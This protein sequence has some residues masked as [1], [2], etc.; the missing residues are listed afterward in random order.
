MPFLGQEGHVLHARR[1]Y[2]ELLLRPFCN[3]EGC[4]EKSW[5]DFSLTEH[6]ATSPPN[7]SP[8]GE[9][10]SMWGY[11]YWPACTFR[12]V[13]FLTELTDLTELFH[14]R[15][16]PT[17][18]LRHTDFTEAFQLTLAVTFCEIGWLH[19]S[20]ECCVFCSSVFF[21][22]EKEQLRDS[23]G[24]FFSHRAHRVHWAFWRTFR[25]HRRPSAYRVHRALLL[26]KGVRWWVLGVDD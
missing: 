15:F 17:E 19:V 7:P 9:G 18:G 12:R 13:F 14:Q 16:E 3:R 10:S 21:L 25:A 6:T 8:N 20:V 11:P 4:G 22:W 24:R 5:R 23:L 1:A 26:K 2:S